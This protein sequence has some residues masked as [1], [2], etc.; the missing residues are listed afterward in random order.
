LP[1]ALSSPCPLPN[2]KRF[3]KTCNAGGSHEQL[4]I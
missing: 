4:A 3:K 2:N 1:K